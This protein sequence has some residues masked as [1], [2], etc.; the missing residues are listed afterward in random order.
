MHLQL[1][2]I[3]N[4][5]AAFANID[6]KQLD[7]WIKDY[8][9]VAIFY[10]EK[11]KRNK[12]KKQLFNTAFYLVDRTILYKIEH[13]N[14]NTE[15][16]NN[17]ETNIN[18]ESIETEIISEKINTTHTTNNTIPENLSI[19]DQIMQEINI[20]KQERE[21]PN[22]SSNEI[23][24]NNSETTVKIEHNIEAEIEIK[25]NNKANIIL[26]TVEP[27]FIS[28]K[29]DTT[30]TTE[31]TIP[32]N[33]SIADQIMQEI[34]TLKQER[35]L[36]DESSNEIDEDNNKTIVEIE[37]NIEAEKR[38]KLIDNLDD[39]NSNEIYIPQISI[40]TKIDTQD[41]TEHKTELNLIKIDSATSVFSEK[42]EKSL[43]DK[44]LEEILEL[45]KLRQ[46]HENIIDI[47]NNV[48][49][50]NI[51]VE[52]NDVPSIINENTKIE[53]NEIPI[54]L[55][56]N[57]LEEKQT[58]IEESPSIEQHVKI[59]ETH[60]FLEWLNIVDA[61]FEKNIQKTPDIIQNQAYE[62]QFILDNKKEYLQGILEGETDSIDE[63]DENVNKLADESI[64]FNVDLATET[65]A[66][67]FKKQGKI[68]K[69]IEV[70]KKLMLKYPE[71][72]N[73]FETQIENLKN[74]A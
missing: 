46:N 35:K 31:S 3:I 53:T 52:N 55:E 19:A 73:I 36:S 13:E 41:K 45:K 18:L 9:S 44:I 29:I 26:E 65:L 11:F 68:D 49:K 30:I 64:S 42:E 6:D 8:P 33:L 16:K 5:P 22:E 69:A 23:I 2:H 59:D 61:N 47:D 74:Q 24:E 25:I 58:I 28:E 15:N 50:T 63:I 34:N 57:K 70:Y 72:S 66:I 48:G 1:Q 37:N 12:D 10:L 4:N 14:I 20:L 38:I 51:V 21:I 62:N 27:E 67:I 32:E 71:K 43:A 7:S 56:D 54:I 39:R 40:D 60:T 17:D